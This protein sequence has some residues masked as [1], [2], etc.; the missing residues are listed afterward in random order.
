LKRRAGSR[1]VMFVFAFRGIARAIREE[2]NLRFHL[3]ALLVVIAAGW[4]L[5]IGPEGWLWI[6]S[7]VAAVIV[8]ELINTAIERAVDLA[9]PEA[10]PLAQAAKDIAA[11]AVIVAALYAVFV[12]LIVLG[13]PL[14]RLIAG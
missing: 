7:A 5:D 8:T 3:A 6:G 11:G 9:S 2:R 4:C 14:W 10:H 13:P 1:L 12:G